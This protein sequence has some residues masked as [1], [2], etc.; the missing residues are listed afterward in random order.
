MA[1]A[2]FERA[3]LDGSSNDRPPL[4]LG[5]Y[6]TDGVV[7]PQPPI[8]RGLRTVVD[9]LRG[10]G[11]KV[12]LVCLVQFYFSLTDKTE[13]KDRRME[14]TIAEHCKESTCNESSSIPVK[15]DQSADGSY[16]SRF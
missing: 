7:G 3:A 9:T 14:S 6:W 4:K 11:H 13:L 2:V 5:I 1:D 10:A 15:A 12:K 16:S 8:I